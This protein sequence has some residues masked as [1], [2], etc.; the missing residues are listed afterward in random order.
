MS[1]RDQHDEG[2]AAGHPVIKDGPGGA[3]LLTVRIRFTPNLPVIRLAGELDV[4]S[5]HLLADALDSIAAAA[6]SGNLVLLDLSGVRFC[7]VAGLRAIDMCAA[8]LE[9]ADKQLVL[10]QAP[11]QVIKLI[12]ITGVARHLVHR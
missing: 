2:V 9:A 10:Y 11:P 7:D 3:P 1:V 6:C 8:A 5:L 12:R 4:A